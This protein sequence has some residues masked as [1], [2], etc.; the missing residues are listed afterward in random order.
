[1]RASRPE[2]LATSRARIASTLPSAV[3]A[4]PVARPDRTARAASMLSDFPPCSAQLTVRA[5]D[6]H[7]LDTEA[8][9]TASK[10][11]AIGTGPSTPTR[12]IVPN[13]PNQLDSEQ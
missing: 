1:M 2:R 10:P 13:S 11:G 4:T 8:A 5:V 7:H 12:P 9:Q 3:L 6:L